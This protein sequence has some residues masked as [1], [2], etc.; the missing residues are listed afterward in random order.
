[1]MGRRMSNADENFDPLEFEQALKSVQPIW[2]KQS[3]S[4]D[5]TAIFNAIREDQKE[6][7]EELFRKYPFIDA[8]LPVLPDCDNYYS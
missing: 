2:G 5:N 3:K 6:K 1:M 4:D 8:E 7:R